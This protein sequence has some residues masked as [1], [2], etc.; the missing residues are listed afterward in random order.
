MTAHATPY[1]QYALT[2]G[3]GV[4]RDAF[5][6]LLT[7]VNTTTSWNAIW[8]AVLDTALEAAGRFQDPPY[9]TIHSK[10]SEIRATLAAVRDLHRRAL[11]GEWPGYEEWATAWATAWVL[12]RNGYDVEAGLAYVAMSAASPTGTRETPRQLVQRRWQAL[13][14]AARAA[15]GVSGE[16]ALNAV[17]RRYCCAWQNTSAME[18]RAGL[19]VGNQEVRSAIRRIAAAGR[20]EAETAVLA[21]AGRFGNYIVTNL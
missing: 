20:I 13:D 21:V 14:K 11:R 12:W 10:P 19:G 7:D 3:E 6:P 2:Y 9:T 8:S 1:W 18:P 4:W 17:R 15:W 5:S 16:D